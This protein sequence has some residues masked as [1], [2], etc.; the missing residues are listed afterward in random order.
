MIMESKELHIIKKI[1][2]IARSE[3]PKPW[4]PQKK[5]MLHWNWALPAN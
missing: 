4:K 5:E 1:K 2:K 3:P